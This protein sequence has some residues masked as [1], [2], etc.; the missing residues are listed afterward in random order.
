MEHTT[1]AILIITVIVSLTHGSMRQRNLNTM[2]QCAQQFDILRENNRRNFAFQLEDIYSALSNL[3]NNADEEIALYNIVDEQLTSIAPWNILHITPDDTEGIDNV[4]SQLNDVN[5]ALTRSRS[6]EESN[7][8]ISLPRISR[9]ERRHLS[10]RWR[11]RWKP[12][13][14]PRRLDG[15]HARQVKYRNLCATEICH[16]SGFAVLPNGELV[17]ADSYN[18]DIYIY[19]PNQDYPKRTIKLAPLA[20]GDVVY[21]NDW[22]VHVH[23]RLVNQQMAWLALNLLDYTSYLIESDDQSSRRWDVHSMCEATDSETEPETRIDPCADPG[24]FQHRT[25]DQFG[26]TYGAAYS[27]HIDA[28]APNCTRYPSI[29][30]GRYDYMVRDMVRFDRNMLYVRTDSRGHRK[31]SSNNLHVFELFNL[32]NNAN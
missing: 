3:V 30:S 8:C 23:V 12:R 32:I 1:W 15:T 18:Y 21:F 6:R 19:T 24:H 14:S 25:T 13:R 29:A 10:K 31:S 11:L 26:F 28:V 22:I 27:E 9:Q 7:T 5:S 16:I 4:T 17:A 2:E 20:L